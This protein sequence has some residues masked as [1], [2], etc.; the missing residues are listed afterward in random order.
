MKDYD[1][2]DI[3]FKPL[4]EL[5]IQSCYL[6]GAPFGDVTSLLSSDHIIPNAM[7]PR[8]AQN[9]PQLPVHD[10]C[11]RNKSTDDRHF[12]YMISLASGFNKVAEAKLGTLLKKA[13][14]ESKNIGIVGRSSQLTNYKFAKTLTKNIQWGLDIHSNGQTYHQMKL[15]KSN[16][17]RLDK[18]LKDLTRGLFIR[19]VTKSNPN[20]PAIFTVQYTQT[21]LSGEGKLVYETAQNLLAN[22]VSHGFAQ[23]WGD[24][25]SYF[26]SRTVESNN[27]G[28]LYIHFYHSFGA[29]AAFT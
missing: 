13:S 19:N 25:V 20:L 5:D 22:S 28:Y 21:V 6:C 1:Y 24:Q 27:K 9:Q 16:L 15:D 4:R 18:Y 2:F 10:L 8:G 7:F 23:Q 14:E 11:H 17:D 12:L 26:G 29:L 3:R